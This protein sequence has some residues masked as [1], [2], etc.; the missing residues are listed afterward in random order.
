M[1]S[2]ILVEPRLPLATGPHGNAEQAPGRKAGQG[3]TR[4]PG[5]GRGDA[6]WV[7]G[8][9]GLSERLELEEA[10]LSS[11]P[12][13]PT[14]ETWSRTTP[15]TPF[16]TPAP[17]PPMSVYAEDPGRRPPSCAT[18]QLLGVE[19]GWQGKARTRLRSRR[20]PGGSGT[21]EVLPVKPG[22]V[23]ASPKP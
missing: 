7:G 16:P 19:E 10:E 12:S 3:V 5:E 20:G 1:L 11:H 13:P 4:E 2:T 6:M 14:A 8:E 17:A 15:P 22:E 21:L 9:G 23:R 18:A